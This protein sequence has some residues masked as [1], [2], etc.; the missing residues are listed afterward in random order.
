MATRDTDNQEPSQSA[1]TERMRWERAYQNHTG[2]TRSQARAVHQSEQVIALLA[3]NNQ[4]GL[5]AVDQQGPPPPAKVKTTETK[6]EVP[7]QV[8]PAAPAQVAGGN[9]PVDLPGSFDIQAITVDGVLIL[10]ATVLGTINET[11]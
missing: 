11:E 2:A 10:S 9:A 1:H 5:A 6:L 4:R 8:I 3:K 7:R